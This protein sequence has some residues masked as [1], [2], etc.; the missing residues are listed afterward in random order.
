VNFLL[1]FL[2][3]LTLS[4]AWSALIS[5]KYHTFTLG[6]AGGYNQSLNSPTS[7][8]HVHHTQ[9]LLPLPNK[10]AVSAWEDPSCF[11][12]TPWSPLE[13]RKALTRQTGIVA[14]N[15]TMLLEV[16]T[17][18]SLFSFAILLGILLMCVRPW[19][20]LLTEGKEWY[21][22]LAAA[23]Y[24]GGYTLVLV[25][26]RFFSFVE[27]LLVIM[28]GIVLDRLLR[29][30]FFTPLRKTLV[31]TAFALSF[32]LY[33]AGKLIS[34]RYTGKMYHEMSAKLAPIH[35]TGRLASNDKWFD[36]FY[37]ASLLED[38]YLGKIRAN[39]TDKEQL[40]RLR[41]F[42][43]DYYLYWNNTNH[44]ADFWDHAFPE[45]THGLIPGLRI[46]ALNPNR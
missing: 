3:F 44:P 4:G 6:T 37:L 15:I 28:G 32:M 31:L 40:A 21:P 35:I 25:D 2:V 20:K 34:H 8:G 5:H 46:Y 45:V 43:I 23:I 38:Q 36:S 27:I 22:L 1:G 24:T 26:L 14:K 16:G 42:Q 13:S 18:L 11:T 10:T 39:L 41:E 33:P 17:Q 7:P 9:G 29:S 19:R 12:Y 30:D